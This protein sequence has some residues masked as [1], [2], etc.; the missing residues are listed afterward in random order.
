MKRLRNHQKSYTDSTLSAM[1]KTQLIEH[2]RILE[3]NIDALQE[4]CD[5]QTA[6][7][8]EI[9]QTNNKEL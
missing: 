5:N 2:I 1:T 7:L 9:T 8:H 3:Q 6:Y 4:R